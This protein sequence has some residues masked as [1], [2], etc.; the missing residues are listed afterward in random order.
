MSA[1][2]YAI[3]EIGQGRTETSACDL[4]NISVLTFKQ[5]VQSDETLQALY[6]DAVQRGSDA[7]VDAL[8][9]VDTHR[10][11]GHTD[12]KM[13]KVQSDNIKWVLAKRDPERFGERIQV[14]H[15]VSLDRV[16]TD[17]LMAAKQR[18]AP[19]LP[20]PDIE[21]AVVVDDDAALLRTLMY[22]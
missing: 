20:P 5:T 3:N 2:L 16:I 11:Y 12:S 9:D 18:S 17:V 15:D 6:A 10:I 1:A 4:A 22:G 8:I 14:K 7:L 13:A 19:S 21:D